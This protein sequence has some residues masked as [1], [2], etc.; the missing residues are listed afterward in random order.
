MFRNTG[1]RAWASRRCSHFTHF[2]QSRVCSSR[3]FVRA[4]RQQCAAASRRLRSCV[5]PRALLGVAS[6]SRRPAGIAASSRGVAKTLACSRVLQKCAN[7][8][9]SLASFG[10]VWHM[11]H[12][13]ARTARVC[14]PAR[15]WCVLARMLAR[16]RAFAVA[17]AGLA[18]D[19][20]CAC[21][22]K[23]PLLHGKGG[24]FHVGKYRTNDRQI[25][26]SPNCVTK[27]NRDRRDMQ[28]KHAEQQ[29]RDTM[30]R[31]SK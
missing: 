27:V 22:E 8:H 14:W 3:K 28:T 19:R 10:N 11:A 21:G 24:G 12:H 16:K 31:S 18:R 9:A 26:Y 30:R 2:N 25:G 5:P 17:C 1:N 7:I 29:D 23:K 20:W 6:R 4:S 13:P 15:N